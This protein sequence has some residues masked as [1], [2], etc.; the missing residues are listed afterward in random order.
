MGYSPEILKL[1]EWKFLRQGTLPDEPSVCHTL[2]SWEPPGGGGGLL[3]HRH[4]VSGSVLG[5]ETLLS[6][7]LPGE[8]EAEAAMHLVRGQHS[9]ACPC[10]FLPSC[11]LDAS[12]LDTPSCSESCAVRVFSLLD[13]APCFP[14]WNELL[15]HLHPDAALP[16]LQPPPVLMSLQPFS[17]CP[18]R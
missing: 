2:R 6:N 8:A 15:L 7:R 16:P 3:T 1:M 4:G 10:P 5:P 12:H 14:A 11:L 17:G 13:H 9:A 18:V